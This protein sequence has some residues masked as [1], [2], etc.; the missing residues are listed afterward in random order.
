MSKISVIVFDSCLRVEVFL[1][2]T[3]STPLHNA[4]RLD[5]LQCVLLNSHHKVVWLANSGRL[6]S[7]GLKR[8][9][10]F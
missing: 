2:L 1:G 7:S 4:T 9:N 5:F 6:P 10:K 8:V 3:K